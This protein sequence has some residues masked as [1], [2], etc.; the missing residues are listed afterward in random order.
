[1]FRFAHIEY[2]WLLLLVPALVAVMEWSLAERKRKVA[3]LATS[4][5]FAKL[6]PE[7]STKKLRTKFWLLMLA[8]VALI[9]AAA[10]PQMGSKLSEVEREG[11][12]IMVAVD[13]SNSMLA[14]DFA[15]NRLER[16]KYAV[17]RV[18]EGLSEDRIGVIVFAGDAYVQLPITAD[19]LTARNFVR[20]I[21]TSQVT[22]QGTAIGAAIEL[23]TR[24]FSSQSESSRVL[25]L[26]TDGENHED[27]ALA[28]AEKAAAQGVKIYTI[29]IGTPEGAPISIGDDFIRDEKGE[30]VVSKLDE[31]VLQKIAVTTGGAYVRATTANVGLGDIILLINRT[32]KSKFKSEVF[33][34]YNELYPIPLAIALALLLLECVVLP[35]KN[36]VLA[37][38]NLFGEKRG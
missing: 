7:S 36:R 27:D 1:M 12:E 17:E 20:Q 19:Y 35:R 3:R 23:A 30:I 15:P 29:G 10:R 25:V 32:E 4:A 9:F 31:E 5:A 26:V 2:F 37:R 33:E 28:M 22:R 38:F 18:I 14:S 6:S 13:V 34:E 8:L 11:V 21:S 16:T 24:S